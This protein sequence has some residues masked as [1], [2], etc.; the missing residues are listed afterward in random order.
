MR[1]T[2]IGMSIYR[3]PVGKKRKDSSPRVFPRGL[4]SA[5]TIHLNFFDVKSHVS[6]YRNTIA[7]ERE[8]IRS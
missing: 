8:S 4:P 6:G 7:S 2:V 1:I 5:G 3:L